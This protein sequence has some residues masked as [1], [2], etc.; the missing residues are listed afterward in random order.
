MKIENEVSV[1]HSLIDNG[2]IVVES[3]SHIQLFC[4]PMDCSPPPGSSVHRI[5][6]ARILE[7][8]AISFQGISWPRNR[9]H[10]SCIAGGFFTTEPLLY[11]R[12]TKGK[13][14]DT[15]RAKRNPGARIFFRTVWI[16][17]LTPPY[18]HLVLQPFETTFSLHPHWTKPSG[19]Q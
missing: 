8:V 4:Y 5:L 11:W 13:N 18:I 14:G 6:Q 3:L 16:I 17:R 19:P 7:W 12:E 15:E 9:T 2:F 10:V 1:A